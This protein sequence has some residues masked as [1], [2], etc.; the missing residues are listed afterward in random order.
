MSAGLWL[1]VDG[2]PPRLARAGTSYFDLTNDAAGTYPLRLRSN[3]LIPAG[4][5]GEAAFTKAVLAITHFAATTLQVRGIVDGRVL[6]WVPVPLPAS[7]TGVPRLYEVP[8]L[9]RL[10]ASIPDFATLGAFAPRGA[11]LELE[12][13]SAW[14]HPATP[15]ARVLIEHADVEYEVVTPGL[16]SL[17]PV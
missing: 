7:P 16:A 10:P 4:V 14:A 12:V 6:D 1:A 11:W 9:E 17:A 15:A 2:T 5:G 13:Q 3:R 8:L